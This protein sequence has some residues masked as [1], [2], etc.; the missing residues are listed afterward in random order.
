MRL[1]PLFLLSLL[2][3]LSAETPERKE[4]NKGG[5]IDLTSADTKVALERFKLK[6]GYEIN[7]YASEIEFPDMG[8]PIGMAWDD[9][10]RLWLS[11]MP[12]YPH[13]IPGEKPDDKIVILEDANHDGKA[14]SCKVFADGLYLPT[15]FELGDGGAYVGLQPNIE[16]LKDTDGDDKYDQREIILHG[17]GTEDSHHAVHAFNWGPDGG[18]YFGEGV[19]LNS[20]VETPKGVVRLKDGGWF[21]YEPTTKNFDVFVSY[22]FANPWGQAWDQWG[23]N[24]IADASGG[25]NYFGSAITGRMNFPEKHTDLKVFTT[26]VRPT[27]GCELVASRHFP[28]DAQ[29]MFLLNNT[30]GFQGI[31]QH[32][33][34]EDGSGYTSKEEEPLLVSD[35][36]NFRPVAIRFGP[37]G[38]LYI[39]DWWNPLIGHMQYSMRDERRDIKRGRVWRITAKG[40]PLVQIPKIAG[41]SIAEKLDLL[42]LSEDRTRYRARIS[43]REHPQAD[44]TAALTKW[45][46]ALDKNSPDY[47]RMLLEALWV[48]QTI[49]KPNIPLLHQLLD[50]KN[51]NVRSG[52][53]RALRF[54]INNGVSNEDAL[55]LLQTRIADA[56]PR[57]RLEAIL[58]LSFIPQ[59]AAA[60]VALDALK[61]PTDYYIDYVLKDAIAALAPQWKAELLAGQAVAKDNPAG[62]HYLLQKLSADEIAKLS[63]THGSKA[64][65]NELLKRGNG[66]SADD[67]RAALTG[68][69]KYNKTTSITELASALSTA[70][71][72]AQRELAQLLANWDAKEIAAIRADVEKLTKNEDSTI[73]K[74]SLVALVRADGKFEPVWNDVSKDKLLQAEFLD[75]LALLEDKT[76]LEE[77]FS[78]VAAMAK[79]AVTAGQKPSPAPQGRYVRLEVV[80]TTKSLSLAEMQAFSSGENIALKGRASQKNTDYDSPAS[81]AIDGK[82]DGAFAAKTTAHTIENGPY[83]WFEVDLGSTYPLEQIVLWNRT[84]GDFWK[85]IQNYKLTVLDGNRQTVWE[86]ELQPAFEKSFTHTLAPTDP[87]ATIRRALIGALV[88]FPGND[89]DASVI[90]TGFAQKDVHTNQALIALASLPPSAHSDETKKLLADK[91][92]AWLAAQPSDQRDSKD[93]LAIQELAKNFANSQP[94]AKELLAKID[95]TAVLIIPMKTIVAQMKF[96]VTKFTVGAGQAV[97]ID[98]ENPDHMQ[99]NLVFV[100]PGAREEVGKAA[101]AMGADGFKKDFIPDSMKEKIL[102]HTK[103]VDPKTK[104]SLQF[105]APEKPGEYPYVCTFIGHWPIMHGMMVVVLP[106]DPSIGKIER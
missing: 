76:L 30:I 46:A 63:S 4:P 60:E 104:V 53:T 21:R 10:G 17:F 31:K 80:G 37:D 3:P 58:T 74:A 64:V 79:E 103:L 50:A 70:Q 34:L 98:F 96:D 32:R 67:R 15:G 9:R 24:F 48:S 55:K 105:I 19:F 73:R 29:G 59:T 11:T 85:R 6:D 100:Q 47:E 69:A 12:S 44:V 90:L 89:G 106:G 91:V 75:A 51:P 94:N 88:R 41:A 84:D 52:A 71:G 18:L 83:P 25:A 62:L 22:T 20:Q 33:P 102:A 28:D 65:W 7:L 42:K 57:A 26:I 97:K 72:D 56:A 16:F 5:P 87:E 1:L 13:L 78:P 99:H 95:S 92:I 68:L 81:L 2:V 38:A 45:I 43:L 93:F 14:D 66:I 77:L 23:T 49:G 54:Y 82:T 101:D 35:D 39:V 36:P 40:R 86:K 27:C 8:K 61:Q